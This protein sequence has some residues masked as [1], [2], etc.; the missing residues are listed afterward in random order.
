MADLNISWEVNLNRRQSS[1]DKKA[2]LKLTYRSVFALP[3]LFSRLSTILFI[4]RKIHET[5]PLQFPR[6]RSFLKE[7]LSRE[8][9][10]W[11][12][13]QGEG[14]AS[15]NAYKRREFWPKL[16]HPCDFWLAVS[17]F[18][19]W[20]KHLSRFWLDVSFFSILSYLMKNYG[21]LGGC[22]HESRIQ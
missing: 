21:D 8:F 11:K 19:R 1:S 3:L 7:K 2:Q 17:F 15:C 14:D 4:D 9:S 12:S 6:C 16:T 5:F 20:K 10:R 13:S 22:Y 18:S